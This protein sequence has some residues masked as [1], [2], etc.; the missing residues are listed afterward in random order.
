MRRG[1]ILI[2]VLVLSLVGAASAASGAQDRHSAPQDASELDGLILR[3]DVSVGTD[4]KGFSAVRGCS[5]TVVTSRKA[6]PSSG[7]T[8]RPSA[9]GATAGNPLGISIG[10]AVQVSSFN[11]HTVYFTVG[12]W[13]RASSGGLYQI[14]WHTRGADVD[15]ACGPVPSSP[16]QA[17]DAFQAE[18]M[19]WACDANGKACRN[20]PN[21]EGCVALWS[22]GDR[23]VAT[24]QVGA[25]T[26]AVFPS[27][28]PI[29]PPSQSPIFGGSGV[30]EGVNLFQDGKDVHRLSPGRYTFNVGIGAG[31]TFHLV[32]P[33]VN[34]IARPGAAS[35]NAI[36]VQTLR[37]G[38]YVAYSDTS[39]RRRWTFTVG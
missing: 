18:T 32:G 28:S 13:A 6:G 31:A 35:A 22:S 29:R 26:P 3:A 8:I 19:I 25:C 10:Q 33:G 37:P 30:K 4:T 12:W 5:S 34:K 17:G 15:G 2:S 1:A 16:S 11:G 23:M 9:A 27:V 14:V 38:K 21:G 7:A 36:W 39:P 24:M 20:L